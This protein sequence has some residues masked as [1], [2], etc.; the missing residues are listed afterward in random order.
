[1][2]ASQWLLLAV[3]GL[4]CFS[5]GQVWLVQVSSYPLWAR[6]GERE[7]HAYHLAWWRST[8]GVVLTPAA[9]L[10]A[11]STLMLWQRPLGVPGWAIWSGFALQVALLIGTAV[12]WGPLMARL[13]GPGGALLA[14]RYRLLLLTHWL[15][16]WIVT[17]Y[18]LLALWMLAQS[19]WRR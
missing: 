3:T 13:E 4:G 19:A 10:A 2:G 17:F 11:C 18:A 8:W 9:L 16:V 14:E 7:F 15:R 5:A 12:W 6:V 1:M